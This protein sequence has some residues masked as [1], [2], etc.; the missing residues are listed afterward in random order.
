MPQAER[1]CLYFSTGL[2]DILLNVGQS[3]RGQLG[4]LPTF[5][6][7]NKC[8]NSEFIEPLNLF[9]S[10]FFLGLVLYLLSILMLHN[11][12]AAA[13]SWQTENLKSSKM[14]ALGPGFNT[15][16]PL[17]HNTEQPIEHSVQRSQKIQETVYS[18]YIEIDFCSS[19]VGAQMV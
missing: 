3:R 2:E 4:F 19:T 7:R 18:N 9:H 13:F 5:H 15:H 14:T 10:P 17:I 1:V 8:W 12:M 6:P 11:A 16:Y